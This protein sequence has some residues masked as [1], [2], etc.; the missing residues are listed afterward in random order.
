MDRTFEVIVNGERTIE[1]FQFPVNHLINYSSPVRD[2]L[3][4]K[5][6]ENAIKAAF[7]MSY[8]IGI[9]GLETQAGYST[10]GDAG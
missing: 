8:V 3:I 5:S 9:I 10:T 2:W 6:P 7:N 4:I 1:R